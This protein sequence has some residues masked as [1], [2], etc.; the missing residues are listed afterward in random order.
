[1]IPETAK[2]PDWPRLVKA[3]L[4]KLDGGKMAS[5][6]A[7]VAGVRTVTATGAV[8][9]TDYLV[10]VNA[11]AGA[12]TLTLPTAASSAGRQLVIKKIDASV[13]A[14]TLDGAGTETID[15]AATKA[16]TTQYVAFTVL[17][18]GNGWW[19]V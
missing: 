4:D 8:A 2:R 13:N 14:V 16:T 15:G 12:V 10:L 11:T 7:L 5:G 19:I 9:K 1:M 17:C 6:A 18:D 3:A